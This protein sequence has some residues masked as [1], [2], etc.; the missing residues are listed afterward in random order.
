MCV[1]IYLCS[2]ST[3]Y[4]NI[5]SNSVLNYESFM[6]RFGVPFDG[7]KE[8]GANFQQGIQAL[9]TVGSGVAT[10]LAWWISDR[11]LGRIS[12]GQV[13]LAGTMIAVVLE[14]VAPNPACY[15]AG[16]FFIGVGD[17]TMRYGIFLWVTESVIPP[18]VSGASGTLGFFFARWLWLNVVIM[19]S[20]VR[21]LDSFSSTT[22]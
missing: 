22:L 7:R 9:S 15:C 6:D 14:I 17:A 8:I 11:W 20:V 4:E 16:R 12:M 1:L 19:N 5:I 13:G 21:P 10:L 18:M 2:L 3:G